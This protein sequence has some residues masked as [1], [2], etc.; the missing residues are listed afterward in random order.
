MA[1]TTLSPF[2]PYYSG[3]AAS[4]KEL[5]DKAKGAGSLNWIPEHDQIIRRMPMV[6]RVGDTLY[7]S[8]AAELL[9]LAQ[10]ATSY[11]VKCSGA[12]GEKAFGEKT[13]IVG[14]K[15]GDYEV[16]TEAH[17]QMWMKFTPQLETTLPVG[18]QSAERRDRQGRNRR[19][20]PHHWHERCGSARSAEQPLWT[21]RSLASSCTRKPLEQIL[22]SSFLQR[23]DFATPAELFYILALGIMIAVLIYRSGAFGSAVLGGIAVATVIGISWYAF[24]ALGWL[25]DPIYPAIAL[26]AIY[27]AGTLFV[28]LRTERERNRVRHAFSHYM[29]PALV[30]RLAGDPSRLKL[31]GETRDMT[32]LFSDVRG[33]TTISEGLDAE[34]L[35]Q[36]LNSLFTPLEQHHPRRARHDRQ[37]HGRCGD[38]LL[39]RAARRQRSSEP[40]L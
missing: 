22:E 28:F 6:V 12:S 19:P 36:F 33:F 10:G 17:G 3:A 34:E 2:A 9:R 24:D 39:E 26:T 27:L 1:A 21:P 23:P 7:P 18:R 4:L 30:E 35:T 11:F 5:Q 40:R 25:V 20:H 31:G 14:V 13:G 8:F 32:L 29:A 38:G 15:V 16:P 37:V